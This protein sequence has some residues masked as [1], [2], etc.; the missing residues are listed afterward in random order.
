M[1]DGYEGFGE[2]KQ[3]LFVFFSTELHFIEAGPI[4]DSRK[5][6]FNIGVGTLWNKMVGHCQSVTVTICGDACPFHASV[7]G[8]FH[9][10]AQ[11]TRPQGCG[12]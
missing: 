11:C 7:R 4:S 10:L 12:S 5:L 1:V 2:E 8:L 6:V 9:K 3:A